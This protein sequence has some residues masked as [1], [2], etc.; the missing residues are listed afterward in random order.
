MLVV[1]VPASP[2]L[3]AQTCRALAETV[4]VILA[5]AAGMEKDERDCMVGSISIGIMAAA[6]GTAKKEEEGKV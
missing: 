3:N 4:F 5:A 6:V 1:N 2:S